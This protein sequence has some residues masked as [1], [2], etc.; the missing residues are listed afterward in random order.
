MDFEQFWAGIQSILDSLNVDMTREELM[1]CLGIGAGAG[2]LASQVV[3]G[4]SN[5]IRYLIAGLL[6]SLLGPIL[7][8]WSGIQFDVG[9]QIVNELLVATVGAVVVIVV[10]R[11]VG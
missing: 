10:A 9:M 1:I 8:D 2:W 4:K 3:G 5:L 6:G 7:L 11:L